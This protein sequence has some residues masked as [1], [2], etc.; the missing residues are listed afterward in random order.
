[1]HSMGLLENEQDS[2]AWNGPYIRGDIPR[3]PW[4]NEYVYDSDGREFSLISYGPDG[5]QGG[6]D[7][8]AD[9]G[10]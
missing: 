10:I 1:M 2:A 8:D 3:D 6:E 7:E 4:G 5:E 9:I